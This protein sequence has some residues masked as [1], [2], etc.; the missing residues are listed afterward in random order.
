[1]SSCKCKWILN[2]QIDDNAFYSRSDVKHLLFTDD[3]DDGDAGT[4]WQMK[5]LVL[6]LGPLRWTDKEK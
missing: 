6:Q 4:T 5:K 3:D 1:M 2:V